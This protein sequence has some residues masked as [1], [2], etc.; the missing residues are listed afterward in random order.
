MSPCVFDYLGYYG[1]V[2]LPIATIGV[3]R[4]RSKGMHVL[5]VYF[6]FL[7]I[8][9]VA[10]GLLK[11]LLREPRPNGQI[12]FTRFEQERDRHTYGMPSGHAQSVA[13]TTTFLCTVSHSPFVMVPVSFI[14]GMTLYQ[15]YK[16]RRHT[17]SQLLAGTVI[18]S[19]IALISHKVC[20]QHHGT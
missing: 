1:P 14:G 20:M 17:K 19:L 5:A 10:N 18:G 3:L 2:I 16:F 6:G 13:Y 9:T 7:I 4:T 15:R 11:F 8:N 12:I